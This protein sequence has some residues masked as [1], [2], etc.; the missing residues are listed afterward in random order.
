MFAVQDLKEFNVVNEV[1]KTIVVL[2]FKR[3]YLD[4][5][6]SIDQ[7]AELWNYKLD[8]PVIPNQHLFPI[9]QII[10]R[11]MRFN[12]ESA[13]TTATLNLILSSNFPEQTSTDEVIYDRD[14]DII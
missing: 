3:P 10:T 1:W 13:T 5:V 7:K 12:D 14:N 4:P 11:R 9:N 8:R 2:K 6:G